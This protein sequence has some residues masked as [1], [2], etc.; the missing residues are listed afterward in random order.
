MV[1]FCKEYTDILF[2]DIRI[3]VVDIVVLLTVTD[4]TACSG[5]H[6]ASQHVKTE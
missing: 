2:I 3:V 4:S 5:D 1:L 6:L